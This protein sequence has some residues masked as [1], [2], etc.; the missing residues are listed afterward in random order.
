MRA[1]DIRDLLENPGSSRTVR[2]EEPVA[3]LRTELVDVPEDAPING[4]LV[5][6][7]VVDGIYVKG[8][9]EGRFQMRCARCLKPFERDFD[10]EMTELVSREPGPEDDYALAEDLTLD[11]E[12]MVRDAVGLE[13][14]FAPLC[15]PDCLGLC[16][17]CGGDRNLGECPGH[18]RTDPRWAA[19]DALL[20]GWLPTDQDD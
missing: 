12:P 9:L 8:S 14:P 7:S 10:V 2:L 17:I 6:E 19:L 3:G 4:D 1:I 13:M 15:R 5:L 16:E 11:P 20:D 18:E